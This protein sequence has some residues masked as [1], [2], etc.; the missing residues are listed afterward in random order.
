MPHPWVRSPTSLFIMS[1]ISLFFEDSKGFFK[2][3]YIHK[4]FGLHI[5]PPCHCNETTRAS[6]LP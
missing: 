3:I 5:R 4:S 1:L 6:D 2:P